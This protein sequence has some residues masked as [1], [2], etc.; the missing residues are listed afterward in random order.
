MTWSHIPFDEA[1]LPPV[2]AAWEALRAG[3]L[4]GYQ[5]ALAAL[6][7]L[8]RRRE[9]VEAAAAEEELAPPRPQPD[10]VEA[11]AEELQGE[12]MA[13]VVLAAAEP[14][15]AR[16]GALLSGWLRFEDS[17]GG[18]TA[19]ALLS[20][21]PLPGLN[22]AESALYGLVA[23]LDACELDEWT[24]C[25][26]PPAEAPALGAVLGLEGQDWEEV[27]PFCGRLHAGRLV[28]RD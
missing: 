18:R 13:P 26:A 9:P 14:R 21:G 5:Q 1:A 16:A 24:P 20:G 27:E 11:W 12:P 22:E 15:L 10:A 4:V 17:D 28:M 3:D 19:A 23:L 25:P 7:A 2:R 8:L 6:A